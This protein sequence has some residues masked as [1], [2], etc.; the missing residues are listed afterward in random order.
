MSSPKYVQIP[1]K[2]YFEV[3]DS[4]LTILESVALESPSIVYPLNEEALASLKIY[5]QGH[6]RSRHM[7]LL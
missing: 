6:I 4:A 3:S 2:F 5:S 7:I 1:H